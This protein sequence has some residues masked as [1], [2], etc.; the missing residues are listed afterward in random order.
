MNYLFMSHAQSKRENIEEAELLLQNSRDGLTIFELAEQ[1]GCH[2]T[3]VHRYLKEIE[4][5]RTLISPQY[6]HYR[7]DPSESLSNVRLRPAEALTMYLALRRFIRQTSKAP[8]FMISAIQ[9]LVPALQRPDLV[10]HLTR[11]NELLRIDRSATHHYADIWE[12]LV[13]GW[14]E[15]YVVRMQYRKARS[16]DTDIHDIEPYLFEPM[17]LGDGVYIIAWSRQRNALRTFKPDRVERAM[18]TTQRFD[19]PSIDVNELLKTAWGIW[20]GDDDLHQVEL[21]FKPQVA[22]RLMESIFLPTEHKQLLADGSLRWTA[23][24]NGLL[25]IL[26]WVRGWGDEVIVINP[27]QLREQII[28][29]LRS[30]LAQYEEDH[31]V[32]SWK[33]DYPEYVEE[34]ENL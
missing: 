5:H 31:P 24:V 17:S 8:D 32:Q 21:I 10:E 22:R 18:L 1:I 13:R 16:P 9:K 2:H 19:K 28:A 14:L 30:A 7:L 6:G 3:T 27:P 23:Q 20:Y 29:D 4:Q 25:E 12:T 11:S 33:D 34:G 26:S 15:G